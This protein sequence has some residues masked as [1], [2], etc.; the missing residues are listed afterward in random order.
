MKGAWLSLALLLALPGTAL[1]AEQAAP[2]GFLGAI[3]AV[4]AA[5]VGAL[6]KI[7]FFDIGGMPFVVLWL[8]LGAI[9]FT[10]RMKFVNIRAFRHAIDVVRGRYD[11]PDEPGEVSHFQALAAALSATVGL[12]NIAGV[13]IAIQLGGPGAVFWMTLVGFLGMSSKFT[14]CTLGQMYRIVRQDGS[15]SGGAMHYLSR[16]LAEKGLRPLG[17]V[18][19]G[20]F[21]VFCIGGAFGGGNMFQANQ[22]FAGL[23]AAVPAFENLNWLYG[24]ILALLVGLVI[25]GGIRRIGAVA[26]VLIPSM[27]A[28]YFVAAAWILLT[29]FTEI[30]AAIATIFREAFAPRA[31]IAGGFVAVLVQGVR[32]AAFDNEAGVGSA[33]IC[34]SAARTDEPV[35]EGIVALLEPFIDTI[36]VSNMTAL[37][38]VTTGV[39]A[40]RSGEPDGIQM[41]FDAFSTGITWFPIILALAVFLFAFSTIISWGYYGER[42]WAYL[43]GERT[44]KVYQVIYVIFVFIGAVVNLQ[45]VLNFGDMMILAMAFPNLLGCYLLS[46][47]VATALEDYLARLRSGEMLTYEEKQSSE[48]QLMQHR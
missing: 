40:N 33:P 31:A 48:R 44:L 32:R 39:Y 20:V 29:N 23:V 21:C 10:L 45:S 41:T 46:G 14:E 12:G 38:I 16:G 34:H 3:D 42:S 37:V 28:I 11:D 43:F 15:I 6:E 4:F 19:A 36:V 22:S 13:A 9:F 2:S 35:R 7:I 30:P 26:G 5:I 47:K 17:K 25:I 24:L 18:L 1:A 27:C 8:L